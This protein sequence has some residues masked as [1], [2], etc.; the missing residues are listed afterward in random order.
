ME[1][2]V[3]HP[4]KDTPGS[5]DASFQPA[6]LVEGH[7]SLIWSERYSSVGDFS[8]ES[9]DIAG[10]LKKLPLYTLA[11]D[12]VTKLPTL[13]TLRETSVP[14]VVIAHK[15]AKPSSA[16]PTITTI[17][18]S[19]EC[20]LNRRTTV[21]NPV[22]GGSKINPYSAQALTGVDFVYDVMTRVVT[23]GQ[24]SLA[25]KIPEFDIQAP[26]RPVGYVPP[27]ST[28]NFA[29][30]LGELY[31][32]ALSGI[33][34]EGYGFRSVRPA[35]TTKNKIAIQIYKGRDRTQQVVFDTRFDQID[36]AQYLLS[37]AG[38]K[39]T[40][41]VNGS[42]DSLEV[43]DGGTYSGLSR[44]TI[45]ND[46][47]QTTANISAGSDLTQAMTNLGLVDL[48]KNLP[49][50]LFSGEVSRQIAALYG[51]EVNGYLLGDVVKL[52]GDYGLSQFVRVSEFIRSEDAEGEK[53]YPTFESL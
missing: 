8:R 11:P 28:R 19:A 42:A 26:I 46:A 47:S 27:S 37:D 34:D 49:T 48:A 53:A 16:P 14:M 10:T 31:S 9:N 1:L 12:G 6:R 21:V 18:A 3:L 52:T 7:S 33:A 5:L 44:R 20:L 2:A 38:W 32:W 40:D 51:D 24:A 30:E 43:T 45:Y 17:G 23:N 22:G 50:A 35:D 39:N 4:Y 25:D 41:Q 15:I 36:D 13:V 29:A